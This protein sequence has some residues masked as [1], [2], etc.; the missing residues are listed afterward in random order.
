MK[1]RVTFAVGVAVGYVLG[2]RAGRERY[3]QIRKASQRMAESPAVQG[4]AEAVR[5]RASDARERVAGAARERGGP[6]A[7]FAGSSDGGASSPRHGGVGRAGGMSRTESRPVST[8][9]GRSG[10][11]GG[12]G[13]ETSS[14]WVGPGMEAGREAEDF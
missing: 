14:A 12:Q 10:V 2:T 7:R 11:S 3:D 8:Q 6:L 4:A 1:Y 5:E 13:G 9:G